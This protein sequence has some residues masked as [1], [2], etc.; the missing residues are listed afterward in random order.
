MICSYNMQEILFNG[1][2]SV[3]NA[4]VIVILNLILSQVGYAF[5]VK[6]L[7]VL[8]G[9]ISAI[10]VVLMIILIAI[11]LLLNKIKKKKEN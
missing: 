9:I 10:Y 11:K 1:K 3:F 7:Y 6:H 4:L 2:K 5:I 8:S